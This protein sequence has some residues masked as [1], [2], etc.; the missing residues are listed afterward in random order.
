MCFLKKTFLLLLMGNFCFAQYQISGKIVGLKNQK[1]FLGHYWGNATSI[2]FKD[3]AIIDANGVFEFKDNVPLPE[4]LYIIKLPS[5]RQMEL[6]IPQNQNFSFLTNANDL[7]GAMQFMNSPDNERL[8]VYLKFYSQQY[9]LMQQANQQTKAQ[10]LQAINLFKNSMFADK[11]MLVSKI[12]QANEDLV[13]QHVPILPNG[14]QD[15]VFVYNYYRNHYFDNLDLSDERM[16]RTGFF[17]P[18]IKFYLEK[19]TYQIADSLIKSVDYLISQTKG[20]YVLKRYIASNVTSLYENSPITGLDAVFVHT[21]EKYYEPEPFLW[22]KSALAQMSKRAAILK[23]LLIG[24]VIPNMTATDLSGK[25]ISLHD[26]DS[27][28]TILYIYSLNCNHCKEHA[29]KIAALQRKLAPKGVKFYAVASERNSTQWRSFIK[30]YHTENLLNVI[31]LKNTVDFVNQ[32]NVVEYPT[33]FV[34]DQNKKIIGKRINPALLEKF[35]DYI[36]KGVN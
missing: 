25:E 16:L 14:R 23:P 22:D 12:L 27:R 10:Y 31:D 18:K 13:I 21:I 29:P 33:I 3:T 7:I 19:L 15:S 8:Y 4:G 17:E 32:Y 5:N 28:Y 9:A 24:K 2:V 11:T 6:V 35:I 34:L 26:L 36:E 1:C 30:T 20:N